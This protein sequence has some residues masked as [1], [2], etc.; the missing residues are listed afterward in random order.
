M[1]FFGREKELE[2]LNNLWGKR[3]SSLV[4]CRGR[5]RIGKSTLITEFTKKSKARFIRIEGVRPREGYTNE[6]ELEAFY[7]QLTAQAK[8][9]GEKPKNWL[10]SF[11][12]LDSVLDDR[13]R[14]V[15][16]LDEIS[17]FGHYDKTFADMLKIVWD[18]HWSAHD[19]LVVV[20]C[21][22][23][24][25][26]I[27]EN[28]ID[29]AAF[30]GRRS[31]DVVVRELPLSECV[32]FWGRTAKRID[33]REIIDVLAVT[34]G[35]PRYLREVNPSLSA[36]ENIR[37]MAFAPNTT[38]R[39]D[40]EEM[41]ADVITRQPTLTGEILRCLVEGP[42]S[43]SEIAVALKSEKGGWVSDLLLQL[44]EAGLV[45]SDEGLNPETGKEIRERCYRIRDNYSRFYLK[46]IEPCRHQIDRGGYSFVALEELKGWD[47][48]MGYQFENL[49]INNY[50]QLLKPL[51]LERTVIESAAPYR[52]TGTSGTPG[53]QIDFLIQTAH[54]NLVIEIKRMKDIGLEV[55]REVEEKISRFKRPRGKSFRPVLVY[56]GN[57]S[58]RLETEGYF[59]V[60]LPFS[61][62]MGLS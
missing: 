6:I 36:G 2:E 10:E 18:S 35:V 41:F 5:R 40:F 4:T 43:V 7:A 37:L 61:K 11:I 8:V 34:G 28:F 22:S 14:T 38:L 47:S 56:D 13:E 52:R 1:E 48:I 17:W 53:V 33:P 12:L 44:E 50:A 55:V 54:A 32:K 15:V 16:L 62:L 23:V 46:Y 20:V 45:A 51:H 19:R 58:P 57:I 26:W 60:I 29:N 24:S 49:V 42:K 31:L 59:D 30:L 9:T 3:T 27:R 21:G 39:T 25:S